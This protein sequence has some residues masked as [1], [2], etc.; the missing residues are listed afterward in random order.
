MRADPADGVMR[1]KREF[2]DAARPPAALPPS[3]WGGPPPAT[4]GRWAPAHALAHG[5]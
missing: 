1:G 2:W 3:A 5:T 4:D